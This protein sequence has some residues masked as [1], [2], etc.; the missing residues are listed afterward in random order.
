[1]RAGDLSLLDQCKT[2]IST[3][4]LSGVKENDRDIFCGPQRPEAGTVHTLHAC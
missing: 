3:G 2:S 1:M 4:N